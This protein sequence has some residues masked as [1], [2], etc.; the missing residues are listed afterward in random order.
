MIYEN[1]NV[2]VVD[3][4]TA[5]ILASEVDLLTNRGFQVVG[6]QAY[7][8]ESGLRLF[9]LLQKA[10]AEN[11]PPGLLEENEKLRAQVAELE[12]ALGFAPGAEP[13]EVEP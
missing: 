2:A 13:P 6:F 1:G 8:P 3:G 12:F 7:E 9:A 11:I 5:S 10:P 4:E